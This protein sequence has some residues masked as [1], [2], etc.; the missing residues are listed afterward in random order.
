MNSSNSAHTDL[1]GCSQKNLELL[2][3]AS[4]TIESFIDIMF[5]SQVGFIVFW[6]MYSDTVHVVH[7][8]QA[9]SAKCKLYTCA[10]TM[11]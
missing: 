6:T 9:F 8:E 2:Y 4:Q 7:V 11:T 5:T 1:W 3:K 10:E